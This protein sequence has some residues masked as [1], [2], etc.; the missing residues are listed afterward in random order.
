MR[1][2]YIQGYKKLLRLGS[3][4][5]DFIVSIVLYRVGFR[6]GSSALLASSVGFAGNGSALWGVKFQAV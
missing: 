2:V 1:N 6:G 3:F 5:G 4:S